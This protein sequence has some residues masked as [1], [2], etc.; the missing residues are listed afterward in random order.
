MTGRWRRGLIPSLRRAL[1]V[2]CLLL[3]FQA[4]NRLRDR[5]GVRCGWLG[6]GRGGSIP[7][8]RR[9][10]S[11]RC[12]LLFFQASVIDCETGW[13][14]N[15]DDWAVGAEVQFPLYGACFLSA[16][17]TFTPSKPETARQDKRTIQMTGWT[18]DDSTMGAT[19][20]LTRSSH[21]WKKKKK[22]RLVRVIF[23]LQ[24]FKTLRL[25]VS[26]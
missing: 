25:K 26:I 19:G 14:C 16:A 13:E 22:P 17:C 10:L 8:L 18:Q 2:R 23:L 5:M 12:L 15:A 1:S 7:S 9:V 20:P 21:A 4:R 6:S 11:I 24:D 3:F